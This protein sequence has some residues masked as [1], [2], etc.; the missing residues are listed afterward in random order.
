[1][2]AGGGGGGLA[3]SPA[4]E[5][6]NRAA[7]LRLVNAVALKAR[8][9]FRLRFFYITD[10]GRISDYWLADRGGTPLHPSLP[11]PARVKSISS[12]IFKGT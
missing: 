8:L 9:Q 5:M 7:L 2:T 11:T 3:L 4:A 1:M 10:D 12:F 6:G